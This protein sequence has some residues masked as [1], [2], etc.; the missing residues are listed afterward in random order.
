MSPALRI[1]LLLPALLMA[2]TALAAPAMH[3]Y[4][5]RMVIEKV[6]GNANCQKQIGTDMEVRLAWQENPKQ[7]DLNGW[8]VFANGAPGQL[9]G[10]D[11]AQWVVTTNHA[12]PRLNTPMS[13]TLSIAP[14]GKASGV[15]RETPAAIDYSGRMCYWLEAR[16]TL[17][18]VTDAALVRQRL[19]E[20]AARYAA[21]AHESRADQHALNGE[22]AAAAANIDM[23][24]KAVEGILPETSYYLKTLLT[25]GARLYANARDYANAVRLYRRRLD[26]AVRQADHGVDDPNL[27]PGWQR[28]ATYLYLAKRPEEAREAI[29]RAARLESAV[30]DLDFDS[31]QTRLR[32]Q[33]N[34]YLALKDYE[35]AL[36]SAADEIALARASFAAT[37]LPVYEAR[38]HHA[39]IQRAKGDDAAF[40]A[41]MLPLQDETTARF[42][43]L[44]PLV[45]NDAIELGRHYYA[46]DNDKARPWLEQAY[47]AY[48]AHYDDNI[49]TV[50][51]D[52]NAAFA[53]G[54]LVRIYIAKGLLPQDFYERKGSMNT[55]RIIGPE[56]EA[57][58]ASGLGILK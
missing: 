12:D 47:A 10:K 19:R 16:L 3:A 9:N 21:H 54:A 36:A 39:R 35:R 24:L 57:A 49:D 23:A 22:D 33:A 30:Q 17:S 48:R 25:D 14:D 6:D 50:Q 7:R 31:R 26:I 37:D 41:E 13:L 11:A 29:E 52:D 5:G 53:F 28:L 45:R 42:G 58:R 44:H 46:V 55:F 27:Y 8:I 56:E 34:I 18:A 43:P 1:A 15:L 20:H 32:V 38:S 4:E 2:G 51:G 40:E